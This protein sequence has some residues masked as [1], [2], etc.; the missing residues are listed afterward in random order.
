MYNIFLKTL[1]IIK[2]SSAAFIEKQS[3]SSKLVGTKNNFEYRKN[4]SDKGI[5]NIVKF[6]LIIMA[7]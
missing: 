7:L 4:I 1:R 2:A 6:K 3:S 5:E